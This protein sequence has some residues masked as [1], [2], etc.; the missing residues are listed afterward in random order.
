MLFYVEK[1]YIQKCNIPFSRNKR[2]HNIPL[3]QNRRYLNIP[4][5]YP[6]FISARFVVMK[7]HFLMK[8]SSAMKS[9]LSQSFLPAH[10]SL[11]SVGVDRF[12]L[13]L[14]GWSLKL[15]SLLLVVMVGG[16]VVGQT[17][18]AR[19][20]FEAT[21]ATPTMTYSVTGSGGTAALTSG[22]S[23][24]SGTNA[25][26]T[27][28]LFSEG[29][30]GYR[31]AG[32]TSRTITFSTI[33]TSS[34]TNVSF[35]IKL[36]S[37]S[38]GSSGN[39]A[40]LTDYA[41]VEI[42]P[43]NGTTWYTR[44]NVYGNTNAR[45]SFSSGT[46]NATNT[47]TANNTSTDYTPSGGGARITDGYSTI[48]ISSLP[49]VS[50]LA[51]RIILTNDDANESWLID[52]ARITGTVSATPPTLT[53]A[54]S[55]T[56]D[57]T[58]DVT[59][60]DANSW[61]SNITGITVGGSTLSTSAYSVGTNKITFTPSAS[62]LLQSAGSKSIVVSATGFTTA[63]VS[64]TIGF[65]AATKLG[66]TTQPTA[67][68]SNG[69]VLA[70][71]PVVKIQDQYGNTVT[72][73]SATVTA[74]KSDAG[75]W[76]LGGTTSL[77]A[78]SGVVT[79]TN[80]TATS[81]AA[82]SNATMA[83]TS[84]GLTASGNS[85][86]FN[87]SAPAPANDLCSNATTLAVD[88]NEIT[89]TLTSATYS[90]N[91]FTNASTKNDVWY[92]ITP[93]CSGS[94]IVSVT[95]ATGPDLD[96]YVFSS[97]TCPTSGT[98]NFVSAGSNATSEI[99]TFSFVSGTSYYI[100]VIDFGTNAAAFNISVTPPTQTFQSV[101]TNTASSITALAAVLNGNV[102]VLGNCSPSTHKGFVYAKTSENANPMVNGTLVTQTNVSSIVTGPYNL[103]L[104]ALTPGISYSYNTYVYDGT[105]YTYGTVTTFTTLSNPNLNV[106]GTTAHGSVCP[107][108]SASS[109]TY[110][111]SNTGADASDVVVTSSDPQ[112]V[113]SYLSSTTILANGTATY[114][115]IFTPSSAGSKSATITIYYN[116]STQAT[117]SSVSGTGSASV[118]GV[119]VTNAASSIVNTTATLNGSVTTLGV[120][121]A[122]SEKG[123]V[124]S[125]S[126]TNSDPIVDGTGV[127]KTAVSGLSTGTYT[128]A[129]TG[130]TPVT[131]YTVKSYIYNGS[132]YIYGSAQTFSTLAV[133]TKLGF[134]TAPGST[135]YLNTNMSSFTVQAQRSDNTVDSEYAGTVTLSSTGTITGTTATFV[136][137]IATFSATKF[138]TST[139][140]FTITASLSPL[141]S[142]TSSSISV[143]NAPIALATYT[144][145]GTACSVTALTAS[146]VGSN[147]TVANASVSGQTCNNNSG[148]S[149]SVGGSNWGAA[150]SSSKYIEVSIMPNSN[151]TMSLT[152]ISFD[153][154]RTNAGATTINVRSNMDNYLA[155]LT[156]NISVG[157]SSSNASISLSGFNGQTSTVTF[158]IYGWGGNSTG[159]LRL[160]NIIITGAVS[161]ST[162]AQPST[163]SGNASVCANS[164]QTYSVTAVSGVAYTWSLP[165]NITGS[166]STNSIS[167]TIGSAGSGTITVTPYNSAS[168][169]S[170][171]TGTSRSL[172]VT[173][174]ATNTAGTSSSTPTL[175]VNTPLTSITHA[176]SGATNI[177]TATGLPAGVSAS[178]ANDLITISGTPTALGTFTYSIPLT[179]GCGSVNATGTITV[180]NAYTWTGA[181]SSLWSTSGNW[182]PN[183]VPT[184]ANNV[185]I[186]ASSTNELEVL[187]SLTIDANATFTLKSNAK[188]T[189]NGIIDNNGTFTIESGA[190]LVQTGSG[191]NSGN[192]SYNVKQ[193]VTGSG[194]TV[195]GLTTPNG[196]FWYMGPAL[197]NATSTAF[198]ASAGNQ[199]W[200][201]NEANFTYAPVTSG[202]L[203]QGKSYVL[204]S[205]QTTET[206]NFSGTGL[207]NGTVPITGLTRTGTAHQFRGCHLV[208]NPYP[209]Y[210]DWE[211]IDK[212]NLSPTMY[213]RTA[214]ANSIDVLETYNADDHFGTSISGPALTKFIAPMQGFWVKVAADTQIGSMTMTNAMR[215]HQPT[216]SGLRSTPQDFPAFLRFNMLDGQNK[217]Q[218]ILF[219]TPNATSGI[220]SHDSEKMSASGYA[221]FYSTVNAKKLVI[222]G[223]KN[224]KA[225]TSVPLTLEM[226]SSKSYTFQ[227]EEFNIE[228]GLILLE[229]K[230]EGVI[231]D[232]TINPTYSF[233]G[234]AGTNA[235]RFVVHFQLANAPILVGGPME[236][237]SLG[238]DEL[239]SE[240]IQI[241]SN[242]QG[243]III[244]MDEGFKPEGSVRIFDASGRLVEQSDFNDQ[245]TTIQLNEQAG[246]YF[247]E[248]NTGK[249]MVKKKIVIE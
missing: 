194:V 4:L 129:L 41:R 99:G 64:Q 228:D 191:N 185:N 178:W 38:I 145:T 127:T 223:M 203:I 111:I 34:Y 72:T 94:H 9:P 25:P 214:S 144:F 168:G 66:I 77:T 42:S 165:N 97:S 63:T 65:G 27:T 162:P 51:V 248:V 156:S 82:V 152:N 56:V 142:V 190:T 73:S 225:K 231:Q 14:K 184:S 115:V 80:L 174:I 159:D 93:S 181:V 206:I 123:F 32:P 1:E 21:P 187:S 13:M 23:G 183:G 161:C 166:S 10:S 120:C 138:T 219:M 59:F 141:T 130:L 160:D 246:M 30:K 227:A 96:I 86:T 222:N 3:S 74:A 6:L 20:D 170:S 40:D 45:W 179:G 76:T 134:G 210:L 169:C 95:F 105:T 50:Q 153:Y 212:T 149:F 108:S 244:R 146:G 69:A 36:A 110:T 119:V 148:V 35:S 28:N 177:G 2:S 180:V 202:N 58:F 62:A 49:Q 60:T 163:I 234:N 8:N 26:A 124:Y 133:A 229:D 117:T 61:A 172:A 16:K 211:L 247:V 137:G 208:S 15:L 132:S 239:T 84:S 71:Q 114:N 220:D 209:S 233:F 131:N 55:A 238:S 90:T 241:V 197:S 155:D 200:Q 193:N 88:G 5:I 102:T 78:T 18:I 47:Y 207:S 75:T 215:S 240:N 7:T 17:V 158:R 12:R 232:L 98:A 236:L 31:V 116:T 151:Y 92:K 85:S 143:T 140:V 224:V 113:V 167:S 213:I 24:T 68:A 188:L 139:G 109:I 150:F 205:G 237:E 171:Y 39:G 29:S 126:A 57:G 107:N 91:T 135:A 122:S 218:I 19:Q 189:L 198:L 87:I 173:V 157:T 54:S 176:T 121:P 164:S 235:T 100:R 175:F 196:R 44:V 242:N 201:W 37:F 67:P 70:T 217:D 249:L 118:A 43:D 125:V 33:N 245:E 192:G 230:Q 147:Y 221:Q 11:R 106:S 186:P 199:L 46:G 128:L 182:S 104:G 243:T 81:A 226:P 195:N 103:S 89:G 136:N 52:D 79:F 216:G 83:F 204:R 22:Q 101:T 112:F 48:T 154:L 53:A